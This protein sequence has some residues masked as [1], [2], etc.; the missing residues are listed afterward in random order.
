MPT[1][2]A[3]RS[4]HRS[5]RVE[6]APVDATFQVTSANTVEVVPSVNGRQ[7]DLAKVG[8]AIL[9][10]TRTINATVTEVVPAH[11]TTWAQSLGIKEQVS[12]FT[13]RAQLRRGAREEHPPRRRPAQQHDRRAGRDVLAERHD[14]S[15]HR[16]ARVRRRAGVLRRVHRR[17]RRRREPTRDDDVQRGVL[18]WVRGRVPQAAHDLHLALPDGTRSDGQLSDR[19]PEVP[20]QLEC[21]CLDPHVLLRAARSR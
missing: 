14:R 13:T 20:Q 12:T 16:R 3:P 1:S 9:A 5:R 21:R 7:V 17:R 4:A 15:A 10:G 11:D 19:R 6:Q 18:R 2:C 8:D